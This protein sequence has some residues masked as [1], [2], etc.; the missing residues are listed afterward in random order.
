[1]PGAGPSQTVSSVGIE[2]CHLHIYK[3]GVTTIV[4]WQGGCVGYIESRG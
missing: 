3:L 1:M 2:L 4:N